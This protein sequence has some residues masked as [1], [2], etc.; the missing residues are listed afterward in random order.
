MAGDF[1][2]QVDY[3]FYLPLNDGDQQQ[4]NMDSSPSYSFAN[5]R[6]N[7][8]WLGGNN[9]HIWS[10]NSGHPVPGILTADT[11]GTLRVSRTGNVVSGYF[12]S[13]GAMDFTL[14]WSYPLTT[15]TVRF[16]MTL[17]NQPNSYSALN[18]AFD[19]FKITADHIFYL[20]G[21]VAAIDL[22]LL[23]D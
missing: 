10:M 23:N 18:G 5:V 2:V 6:S 3:K 21:A 16:S 14:I 12:K 9:Y 4:L 15:A 7:E 19:N 22:F 1:D 8:T 11:S 13:P 17:Q 20:G